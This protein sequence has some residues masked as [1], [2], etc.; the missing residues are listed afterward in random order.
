MREIEWPKGSGRTAMYDDPEI[1][2]LNEFLRQYERGEIS[3]EEMLNQIGA[4]H[5]LKVEFPGLDISQQ[6][7]DRQVE[8]EQ[9]V[10]GKFY[11][12]DPTSTERESGTEI[13]LDDSGPLKPGGAGHLLLDQ[14]A[15]GKRMTAYQASYMATGDFH[16]IRR[17]ARRLYMRGFLTKDGTLP[18]PAPRGREQVD[19]FRITE[20]GTL[21]LERLGPLP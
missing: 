3:Q 18:N 2:F 7:G 16:A 11:G 12:P 13:E 14:Y 19:A 10:T 17:E 9:L 5:D 21:E 4:F 15:S 20:A 1:L 8:G 6:N